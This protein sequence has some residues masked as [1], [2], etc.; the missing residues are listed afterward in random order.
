M[1]VIVSGR[2]IFVVEDTALDLS[3]LEE[4]GLEA[5]AMLPIKKV[6]GNG[7]QV[8]LRKWHSDQATTA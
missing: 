6:R 2:G 8:R 3:P 5:A 7:I 1:I 4:P